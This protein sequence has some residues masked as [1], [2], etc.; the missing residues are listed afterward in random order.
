M[1]KTEKVKN[2]IYEINAQ[3]GNLIYVD[4]AEKY[5]MDR[6]AITKLDRKL[7]EKL[8]DIINIG[9]EIESKSELILQLINRE[10]E[11]ER[12]DGIIRKMGIEEHLVFK[13]LLLDS[14][15]QEN[16][17]AV[18]AYFKALKLEGI[19][20][21]R[22]SINRVVLCYQYQEKVEDTL[23]EYIYENITTELMLKIEMGI[24]CQGLMRDIEKSY[25]E[26]KEALELAQKF[27]LVKPIHK[28]EQMMVYRIISHISAIDRDIIMHKVQDRKIELLETEEIRTANVFLE[29][30]LNVS[31]AARKLFIHRNTLIYRLEKIQKVTGYDLKVFKDA[32]EFRIIL[33]TW[34]LSK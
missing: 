1:K 3:Y 15:S 30:N 2:L 28:Y 27:D 19:I 34:A 26:A 23:P 20:F 10:I 11:E 14:H 12:I 8:L 21:A 16:A 4:D 24:G 9:S 13:V 29:C 25:G 18:M 32:M 31:E 6:Q 7:V 17:D 5:Q 22:E 33:L